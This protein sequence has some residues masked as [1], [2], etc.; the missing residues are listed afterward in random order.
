[1]TLRQLRCGSMARG[2]GIGCAVILLVACSST[3]SN[4]SGPGANGKNA[5]PI[6]GTGTVG[7]TPTGSN[8]LYAEC[9]TIGAT[10]SCCGLGTQACSGTV[11]FASWGP[12]LDAKG[13]VLTCNSPCEGSEF[14]CGMVT[15][16]PGDP[17]CG[18]GGGAGNGD[19]G[20]G[21][22][23]PPVPPPGPPPSLCTDKSVNNEPEILAAYSP[24]S[25]EAVAESGQIRV[26][27]N[28]E[29]AAIIAPNESID[30]T[31]GSISS[32]GDRSARAPDN[33]LWEPALYIAPQTA[34]NGGTPHFPQWIK[35][36]YDN[37]P[38]SGGGKP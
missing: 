33:Y 17:N 24:A 4:G 27:I 23:P 8:A 12:C 2:R 37:N 31:T 15:C 1:M 11:E 26:W 34:E 38:Q 18:G 28:D 6:T 21:G 36:W 7:K 3:A 29:A 32:P 19:G 10:R 16:A 13:V 20:G 5:S 25:G 9:T 30:P 14:G 35:G 22:P